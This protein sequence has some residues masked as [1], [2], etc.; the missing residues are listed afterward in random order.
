METETHP[1]AS[2]CEECPRNAP[3]TLR[4]YTGDGVDCYVCGERIEADHTHLEPS[5]FKDGEYEPVCCGCLDSK[6]GVH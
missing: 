5:G 1:V 3:H 4:L 2:S 6:R